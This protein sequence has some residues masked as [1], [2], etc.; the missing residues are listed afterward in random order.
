MKICALVFALGLSAPSCAQRAPSV[1]VV[2]HPTTRAD[3]APFVDLTSYVGQAMADSGKYDPIVFRPTMQIVKDA[4]A[5]GSLTESDLTMPLTKDSSRKIARA[6][7][8]GFILRLT[9]ANTKEGLAG[10]A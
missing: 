1:L 5:A 7:G 3:K 9:A 4:R 8:A 6:L 2:A 10:Q